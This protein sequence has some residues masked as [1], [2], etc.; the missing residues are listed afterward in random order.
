MASTPAPDT[1]VA[2]LSPELA[3]F[4]TY[5]A[6]KKAIMHPDITKAEGLEI[7]KDGLTTD[8][9]APRSTPPLFKRAIV[10]LGANLKSGNITDWTDVFP[11]L[12]I[13]ESPSGIPKQ[14][15]IMVHRDGT[16]YPDGH[17]FTV[18]H[19][20]PAS[21]DQID[22][23][24]PKMFDEGRDKSFEESRKPFTVKYSI[25]VCSIPEDLPDDIKD[26]LKTQLFEFARF[27][28]QYQHVHA[29][30]SVAKKA[31]VSKDK[32]DA[33]LPFQSH[34]KASD[35]EDDTY[36]EANEFFLFLRDNERR[37]HPF[38]PEGKVK[39]INTTPKVRAILRKPY[40]DDGKPDESKPVT[41]L[42]L[43]V[44]MMRHLVMDSKSKKMYNELP[45]VSQEM[46]DLLG[47]RDMVSRDK[48]YGFSHPFCVYAG[49]FR[50]DASGNA[51]VDHT[52]ISLED[53]VDIAK[54]ISTHNNRLI[55]LFAMTEFQIPTTS[56]NEMYFKFKPRKLFLMHS[57]EELKNPEKLVSNS[58]TTEAMPAGFIDDSELADLDNDQNGDDDGAP[59]AKAPKLEPE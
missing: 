23:F 18:A 29:A 19:C 43:R 34:A 56:P 4:C 53:Q 32:A 26:I 13:E 22:H 36:N 21:Y 55:V 35:R 45:K 7:S 12:V 24:Y 49:R 38:K 51:S 31:Y 44:N 52:P 25:D 39:G 33:K 20:F 16:A 15:I 2:V 41:N 47:K 50:R 28:V 5:A 37:C 3:K 1:G 6:A 8:F 10:L 46:A 54:S 57:V 27:C 11:H 58:T 14:R 17:R 42:T 48:G 59:A 30:L 40:G 9:G